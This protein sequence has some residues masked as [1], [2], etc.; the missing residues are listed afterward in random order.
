[1]AEQ[2]PDR[3]SVPTLVVTGGPLDGTTYELPASGDCVIGSSMDANVQILLGNVEPF[4]ARVAIDAVGSVTIADAGSATGTFVNG[5]RVEGEHPLREGDRICLGPPGAKGSAKMLVCLP[6]DQPGATAS[7]SLRDFGLELGDAASAV[8]DGAD[9]SVD[10]STDDGDDLFSAPLPIPATP[11]AGEPAPPAFAP[12][13]AGLPPAPVYAA[14]PPPPARL[15]PSVVPPPAAPPPPPPQAPRAAAPPPPPPAARL[16]APPPPPPSSPAKVE[17]PAAQAPEPPVEATPRP[18]GPDYQTDLPA[19]PVP[20]ADGEPGD[21]PLSPF[22][23]LRPRKAPGAK[24]RAPARRKRALALPSFPLVP[25]LGA[26]AAIAVLG[27]LAWFFL[28]RAKPPEVA[29]ITPAQVEAGQPVTLAGRNFAK[30]PA[31]NVVLFGTQRGVV[32]SASATEIRAVVPAGLAANTPVVVETGGGRS[33]PVMLTVTAPVKAEA[34]V[35]AVA[36]PGQTILVRGE[37]FAGQQVSVRMGGLSATSVETSQEGVRAVV[38]AL[39]LPEGS[40]TPVVVTV[41]G[42]PPR[43]FELL[44]GRLP[45]VTKLEPTAGSA[46]ERVV[47]RGRGFSAQPAANVVTVGGQPALV[48]KASETQMTIVAPAAPANDVQ[49]DLPVVVTANG[50]TS[51]ANATFRIVRAGTG[52]FVPRFYAAPVP[53]FPADGLAFVSTELGPVVLLGGAADA[54]SA[55]ERAAAVADQLN[56]LVAEAA[57]RPLALEAR[58]APQAAVGIV[59]QVRPLLVATPEDVDAYSRPWEGR[60]GGRRVTQAQLSRH[61]AAVLQD[62]LG[63]FLYRQRPLKVLS[64]SSRGKVLSDLYA[65]AARRAPSGTGVPAALVVPVSSALAR[66]LRLMA[67]VVSTEGGRSAVAVEGR[68]TGTVQD[69]ELGDRRIAIEIRAEGGRLGGT[70]TTGQGAVQLRAPLRDVAFD[71]GSVRF[72]ADLQGTAYRFKGTLEGNSVSGTI[73]RAG[74]PPARFTLQYAE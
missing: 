40:T 59:G 50:R 47:V 20:A 74:K 5:E 46:G 37:G 48:L 1:M 2:R 22:P 72:T 57:A 7:G 64:V 58:E 49:P 53:E 69:P 12:P 27:G 41:A 56:A 65:E 31:G 52:T 8:F 34:I 51:S 36:M 25:A 32:S 38:P 21:A 28:M 29:G 30:D 18:G 14:P 33:A 63:L 45:L 66:D 44:V 24:G 11:P 19:F 70:I 26:L 54:A 73:D 13:T 4:H 10:V 6:G 62:F 39:G 55:A 15:Q 23:A 35:P 9:T 17:R 3:V 61:W 68:W 42:K 16:T 71:R 60:G 43:S 67:L